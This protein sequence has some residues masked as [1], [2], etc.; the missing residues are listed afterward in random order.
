MIF[1]RFSFSIFNSSICTCIIS[2]DEFYNEF[3]IDPHLLDLTLHKKYAH[4]RGNVIKVQPEDDHPD[5]R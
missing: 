2:L 4:S 1:T 5:S 3:F